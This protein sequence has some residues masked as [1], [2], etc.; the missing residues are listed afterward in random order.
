MKKSLLIAFAA[1]AFAAC[2]SSSEGGDQIVPTEAEVGQMYL[3]LET[4]GEVAILTTTRAEAS[5]VE[6]PAEYIPDADDFKLTI[7]GRYWDPKSETYMDFAEE[8]ESL[9]AY[10]TM[11]ANESDPTL[12]KPPFL[13]AGEY[14]AVM[15]YGEGVNVESTT[16][17]HFRG[18]V[19]FEVLARKNDGK[20]TLTAT[21]QNSIVKIEAAEDLKNYYGQGVVL[22]LSTTQ[23]TTLTYDSTKP[24][25]EGQL[26]FVTPG[27]TLY[28]SGEGVKQDP[29]D[30]STPTVVF[31]KQAVG[32][33]KVQTL[34]T[35]VVKEGNT[36][37]ESIGVTLD[38]TFT[39]INAQDI[40]LN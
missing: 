17:A 22:N 1:M 6:I 12:S 40:D 33:S 38:D 25:S 37:G 14:T 9:S 30:G 24:E 11:E 16:N 36:G 18:E 2:S 39:E 29:G 7:T 34:S 21:L 31:E 20:T 23:Q 3:N 26:L 27:T 5:T 28:L 10:N 19:S 35:V 4:K 32:V 15:E 13:V 8:Y